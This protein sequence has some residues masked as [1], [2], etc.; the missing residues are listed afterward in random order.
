MRAMILAAGL[1]TRLKPLTHHMAKPLLPVS[2]VPMIR[3]TLNILKKSGIR[4]VM[5]NLHHLHQELREYLIKQKDMRISFS[6]EPRLLDSGGGVLKARP[7]FKNKVS[8]KN[9]CCLSGRADRF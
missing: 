6:H 8:K 3:H 4:E 2:G 5:I 7:F 1:G 9:Y